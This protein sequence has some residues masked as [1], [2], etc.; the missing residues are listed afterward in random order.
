M[1]AVNQRDVTRMALVKIVSKDTD[2]SL[3]L[4]KMIEHSILQ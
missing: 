3:N 2:A 1:F 4:L